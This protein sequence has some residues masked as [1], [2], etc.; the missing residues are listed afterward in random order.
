MAAGQRRLAGLTYY[1]G[2][3]GPDAVGTVKGLIYAGS[4]P[5]G[6]Y[7]VPEGPLMD[8]TQPALVVRGT[9]SCTFASAVS[10][11]S[12]ADTVPDPR[13]T[14]RETV[15]LQAMALGGQAAL[16]WGTKVVH[17]PDGTWEGPWNGVR[18]PDGT[19]RTNGYLTGSGPYAGWVYWFSQTGSGRPSFS[20][21][22]MIYRG[23]PVP[24]LPATSTAPVTGAL[25]GPDGG[26]ALAL[27][28]LVAALAAGVVLRRRARSVQ[29]SAG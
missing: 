1:Y 26:P 16:L 2:L 29:C 20:L 6:Q 22:G 9:A 17:G 12:C 15:A 18:Y 13:V 28:G 11:S 21:D 27:I 8:E 10:W 24:T 23:T 14:G 25:R 4:P 3:V 5:P 19:Y 7:T